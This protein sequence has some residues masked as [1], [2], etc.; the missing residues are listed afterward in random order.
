MCPPTQIGDQSGPIVQGTLEQCTIQ[1]REVLLLN[2]DPVQSLCRVSCAPVAAA[3]IAACSFISRLTN[4]DSFVQN[5]L[6]STCLW[7]N[8]TSTEQK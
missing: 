5:S 2:S 3:D 7:S 4:G 1:L 6:Q 8:A